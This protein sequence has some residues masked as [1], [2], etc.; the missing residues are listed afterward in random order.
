M[1]VLSVSMKFPTLLQTWFV[2]YLESVSNFSNQVE[3]LSLL[4][5]EEP[6]DSRID[7]LSINA[8]HNS[9]FGKKLESVRGLLYLLRNLTDPRT[10]RFL[11]STLFNKMPL[12]DKLLGLQFASFLTINQPDI[13]HCHSEKAAYRFLGLL[14]ALDCPLCLTF[15]GLPPDGVRDLTDEQRNTLYSSIDTVVANTEFAKQQCLELAGVKKEIRVI[16]QGI[17]VKDFSYNPNPSPRNGKY[18]A[19]TVGRLDRLKGHFSAISA[20]K[21]LLQKGINIEYWIVGLGLYEAS[22]KE[23]INLM[24]M[25]ENVRLFGVKSGEELKEIYQ[26]AHFFILPSITEPGLWAE[27]QGIVVQE[28]QAS[29]TLAICSESGGIPE[30]VDDGKDGFLYKPGCSEELAKVLSFLIDNPSHW[31]DWQ[32]NARRK[33]EKDYSLI[34]METNLKTLY[35]DLKDTSNRLEPA[36]P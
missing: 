31:R 35:E 2:N 6:Y 8:V 20:I 27:T 16:P 13:I 3:V 25:N 18:I 9:R 7:T 19:L 15:H 12:K 17:C 34:K 29:G 4:A 33:V 22:I 24:E 14:N 11:K 5:G 30:C 10:K 28:A 32:D 23:K 21:Q 1:K 36:L 26:Q